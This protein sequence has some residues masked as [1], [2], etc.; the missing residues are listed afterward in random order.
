[1]SG[2][3]PFDLGNCRGQLADGKLEGEFHAFDEAGKPAH[4]ATYSAGILHGPM[5]VFADGRLSAEIPWRDG[6]RHGS[7]R[8]YDPEGKLIREERHTAGQ[9]EPEPAPPPA[10]SAEPP[11]AAQ[12][13]GWVKSLL[14]AKA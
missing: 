11:P 8:F 13:P 4:V 1:M 12:R 9:M 6:L 10:A 7:S 14:G 2:D 3:G 5:R